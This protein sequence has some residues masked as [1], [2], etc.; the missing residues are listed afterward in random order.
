MEVI[1]AYKFLVGNPVGKNH[2]G[3]LGTDGRI[4]KL[5]RKEIGCEG[6]TGYIWFKTGSSGG[7]L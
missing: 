7:L 2:L 1:N 4:N 5:H 6:M 3:D